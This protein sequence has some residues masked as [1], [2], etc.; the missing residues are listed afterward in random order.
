[1]ISNDVPIEMRKC[2]Y[3]FYENP[4]KTSPQGI[5]ANDASSCKIKQFYDWRLAKLATA[6]ISFILVYA[7]AYY[8][9]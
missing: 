4:P 5:G 1:M 6:V 7:F 8:G 9:S 3:L 2:L